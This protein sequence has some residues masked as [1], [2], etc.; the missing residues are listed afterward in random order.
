MVHIR[1]FAQGGRQH[2]EYR[3]HS[4]WLRDWD[5]RLQQLRSS[6][7]ALK[8]L[9]QEETHVDEVHAGAILATIH[10]LQNKWDALRKEVKELKQ[11]RITR[12]RQL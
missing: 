5:D 6:Q 4:H 11:H 3:D 8:C 7:E 10:A 9:Q 2:A 12:R 1:A